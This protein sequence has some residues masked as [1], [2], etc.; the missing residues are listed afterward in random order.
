MLIKEAVHKNHLWIAKGGNS[1]KF[2]KKNS[3]FIIKFSSPFFYACLSGQ[4]HAVRIM[5][6]E[7]RSNINPTH[8]DSD[9]CT[10]LHC[11]VLAG[12][13][14]TVEILFQVYYLNYFQFLCKV[15]VK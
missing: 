15:R 5:L 2:I 11:A 10:A 4:A 1:F 8:V 6:E 3:F 7:Q 12:S 14:Q 13:L 9:N